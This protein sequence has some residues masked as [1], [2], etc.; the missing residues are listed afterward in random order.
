MAEGTPTTKTVSLKLLISKSSQKVVYAEADK[1]FV[2]FLFHL[3]SFPLGAMIKLVSSSMVG[4]LGNLYASIQNLNETYLQPHVDKDVL[5]NPKPLI[6]SSSRNNVPLL[7][8]DD[9]DADDETVS[10]YLCNNC[11]NNFSDTKKATCP[12]CRRSVDK[13]IS[14]VTPANPTAAQSAAAGRDMNGAGGF[15]R[16]L[17]TYMVLDDL[18]VIPQST[19]SAITILSENGV[20]DFGSLE[21]K[22]VH[23]G[24]QEGLEVLKAS[25]HTKSVLTTV[26]LGKKSTT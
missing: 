16:G 10:F 5:L 17:A 21:V 11:Y 12:L 19:I 24:F 8:A 13:K 25:L 22:I 2:D 26:F 6:P 14:Y 3:M 4:S 7:L 1:P 9:D 23:L 18:K 15:V 20:K